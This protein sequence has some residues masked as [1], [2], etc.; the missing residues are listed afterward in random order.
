MRLG[1]AARNRPAELQNPERA[2]TEEEASDQ[3][4]RDFLDSGISTE[5]VATA[6]VEAVKQEKLYILTHP[7]SFEAARGRMESIVEDRNPSDIAV[8]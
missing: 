8:F 2:K 7:V 5:Q 4:V 1:D 6:M 3:A